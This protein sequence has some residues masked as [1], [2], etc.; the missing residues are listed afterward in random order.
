MATLK[1]QM[2]ADMSVFINTDEFAVAVTYVS[3]TGLQTTGNAVIAATEALGQQDAGQAAL[4]TATIPQTMVDA[5]G[6][7]APAAGARII[8]TATGCEWRVDNV[9]SHDGVAWRLA[10]SSDHRAVMR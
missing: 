8:E 9:L 10:V 2:Q 7:E 3:P 6:G 5:V 4:G 1:E